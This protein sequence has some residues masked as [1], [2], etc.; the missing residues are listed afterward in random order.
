MF[1]TYQ[2]LGVHVWSS[3]RVLLRLARKMIA[4]AYRS[5]Q[6]Y[7]DARHKFYREMIAHHHN[8]QTLMREWRL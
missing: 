8:E 7:R 2:R 4:P 5:R 1:G 3:N 6:D